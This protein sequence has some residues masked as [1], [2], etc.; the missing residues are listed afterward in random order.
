M[1]LLTLDVV[2]SLVIVALIMGVLNR[3]VIPSGK[4]REVNSIDAVVILG[5][6]FGLLASGLW[7]INSLYSIGY[8]RANNETNQTRFYICFAFMSTAYYKSK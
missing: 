5:M 1:F 3:T 2:Q 7:I 8:M 4:R 6:I